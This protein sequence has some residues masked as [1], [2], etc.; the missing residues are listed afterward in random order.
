MNLRAVT[1]RED[2]IAWRS[3]ARRSASV[4]AMLVLVA[5]VVP[6]VLYAFP[7]AVGAQ[8]S[9]VVLSGSM[10]PAI[11]PGDVVFVYAVAPM[12]ID[13]GDVV[14][15]ERDSQQI[16]T[17]H[18]VIEV[19]PT[20]DFESGVAFRTMGD[21]NEDADQRLVPG[22]DIVGV[23]PAI[24]LPVVGT[25]LFGVPA[26]GHVIQFANTNVGF[27]LLVGV[28]IL[29]FIANEVWA[30]AK[31]GRRASEEED[32]TVDTVE[33]GATER[34]LER[35]VA[36]T[37]LEGQDRR[38]MAQERGHAE[39]PVDDFH[40]SQTDLKA[41][42]VVLGAASVYAVWVAY[43][44]LASW[45]IAVA[46]ASVG[47]FLYL[48]ALRH[49]ALAEERSGFRPGNVAAESSRPDGGIVSPEAAPEEG[50]PPTATDGVDQASPTEAR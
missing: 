2:S 50:R 40:I 42:L 32:H 20:N 10:A 1:S 18:R 46:V 19:V 38:T 26:M 14:M 24:T 8:G 12:T 45:S 17:T 27:V 16:P 21:A 37:E 23:V 29:A 9:Y 44:I 36:A 49:R 43:N 6:F 13:V 22:E 15:F 7:A 31:A 30:V 4:V 34:D 35:G 25:V 5:L 3:V 28:P 47:T 33:P 48:A 39:I 41:T 11:Q